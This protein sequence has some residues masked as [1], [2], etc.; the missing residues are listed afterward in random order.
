MPDPKIH[1]WIRD[2]FKGASKRMTKDDFADFAISNAVKLADERDE[3][4][5]KADERLV[6]LNTMRA[7]LDNL[8]TIK[9]AVDGVTKLRASLA[10]VGIRDLLT[11]TLFPDF[12]ANS[13]RLDNDD[14]ADL[15]YVLSDLIDKSE[16]IV[17]RLDEIPDPGTLDEDAS[18]ERAAMLRALGM[19]E[20]AWARAYGTGRYL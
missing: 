15:S 12:P 13:E 14:A 2:S 3:A 19:T 20:E 10:G 16:A 17:G 1:A 6:L 9:R 5:A 18:S 11:G 4:R 7:E 8:A